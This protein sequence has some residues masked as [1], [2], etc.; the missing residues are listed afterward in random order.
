MGFTLVN[1]SEVK[2][3]LCIT[4]FPIQ[5][6]YTAKLCKKK[7]KIPELLPEFS[8]K[9]RVYLTAFAAGPMCSR[10]PAGKATT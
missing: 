3:L 10:F 9:A 7:K 6:Y 5:Y 1:F 2:A 8:K 4:Y